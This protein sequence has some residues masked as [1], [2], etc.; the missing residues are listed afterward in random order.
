M[1]HEDESRGDFSLAPVTLRGEGKKGGG[2]R[3]T[4]FAHTPG[5]P[6]FILF[7]LAI[8]RGRSRGDVGENPS[9]AR[10]RMW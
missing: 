4:F 7:F 9:K 6:P 3:M 2:L 1:T 10:G 8:D 5:L